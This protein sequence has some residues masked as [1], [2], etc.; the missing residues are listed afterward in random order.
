LR[1]P[2][3][4]GRLPDGARAAG[5]RPPLPRVLPADLAVQ[6]GEGTRATLPDPQPSPHPAI[7]RRDAEMGELAYGARRL[8]ELTVPCDTPAGAA[9]A[10]AD[11]LG[12]SADRLAGHAPDPPHARFLARPEDAG[13]DAATMHASMPYDVVM[14]RYNPLA[15]PI[16]IEARPPKVHGR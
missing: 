4:Q 1:P 16:T 2:R 9:Q 13:F 8:V 5:R 10:V 3:L 11:E 12:A 7:A 6:P 15:L 14:G